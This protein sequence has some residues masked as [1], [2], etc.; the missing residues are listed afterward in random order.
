MNE[1]CR[2]LYTHL[3][4]TLTKLPHSFKMIILIT[5]KMSYI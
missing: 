3:K 1:Y 5:N 2:V 4:N